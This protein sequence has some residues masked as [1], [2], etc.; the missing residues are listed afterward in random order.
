MGFVVGVVGCEESVGTR[1]EDGERL[2]RSEE[3]MLGSSAEK[4]GEVSDL[5]QR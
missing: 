5:G 1:R 3:G 2:E 4:C